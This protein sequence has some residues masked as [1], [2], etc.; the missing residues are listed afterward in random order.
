MVANYVVSSGYILYNIRPLSNDAD[1]AWRY[2]EVY[3]VQLTVTH[4][5][6]SGGGTGGKGIVRD[7]AVRAAAGNRFLLLVI[8]PR[9]VL[10]HSW[11]LM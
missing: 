1:T 8:K 2:T 11:V 3:G 9:P 5:G 10:A 4:S 6:T 7:S